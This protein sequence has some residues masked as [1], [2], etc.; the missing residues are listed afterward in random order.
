MVRIGLAS[1]GSASLVLGGQGLSLGGD[2]TGR[3]LLAATGS[4]RGAME[5]LGVVRGNGGGI[6]CYF[7]ANGLLGLLVGLLA[8]LSS[9]ELLGDLGL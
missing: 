2:A 7:G 3:R 5:L 1:D 9:I 6:V 8:R 4:R